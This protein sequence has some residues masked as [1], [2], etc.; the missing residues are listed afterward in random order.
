MLVAPS[1][2]SP[3]GPPF[4]PET[5]VKSL[6]LKLMPM[7]RRMP[8]PYS[9]DRLAADANLPSSPNIGSGFGEITLVH[10]VAGRNDYAPIQAPRHRLIE[11]RS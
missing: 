7:G 8:R 6:E 2:Y 5:S 10:N 11:A 3:R 1:S 9:R 4:A